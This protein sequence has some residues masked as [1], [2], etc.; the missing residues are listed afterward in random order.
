M[1]AESSTATA[2]VTLRDERSRA[3]RMAAF[4]A[5]RFLPVPQLVLLTLLFLAGVAMPAALF[6]GVTFDLSRLAVAYVATML[7]FF[8]LR[9]MDD[10]KDAPHDRVH[11]AGRPIPR[12]LISERE[13]DAIWVALLAIEGALFWWIGDLAFVAWVAATAFSLLMRLEFFVGGWLERRILTYAISHM[14]SMGLVFAMLVALGLDVAQAA[15]DESLSVAELLAIGAGT[16]VDVL[17][18]GAFVAAYAAAVA[19]GLG[20]ELGRKWER[21]VAPHGRLAYWLWLLCPVA[22]AAVFAAAAYEIGYPQ[23]APLA[24]AAV[25]LAALVAHVRVAF[26]AIGRTA[27]TTQ[28]PK[29]HRTAIELAPAVTGLCVYLVL[30]AAGLSEVNW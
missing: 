13:A 16:P 2:P 8:H 23:W 9:V 29:P 30:A 3:V 5:E 21:Y 27:P 12:G 28:I 14:L 10:V 20:F 7:W 6:D 4:V 1:S 22:G 17:W 24:L 11:E 18:M 25:A 26:G 15:G 19:Q